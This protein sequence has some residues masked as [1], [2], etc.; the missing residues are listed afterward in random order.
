MLAVL[1]TTLLNQSQNSEG[2]LN[3]V[4]LNKRGQNLDEKRSPNLAQFQYRPSYNHK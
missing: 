3:L 2:I 4:E 1:S